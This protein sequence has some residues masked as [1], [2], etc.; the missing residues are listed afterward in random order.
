M[1]FKSLLFHLHP[2]F[3]QLLGVCTDIGVLVGVLAGAWVGWVNVEILDGI[4]VGTDVGVLVG[5]D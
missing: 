4:A 2:E 1:D 3:L 5:L